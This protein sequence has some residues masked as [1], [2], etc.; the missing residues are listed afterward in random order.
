MTAETAP[1]DAGS[2][3][4]RIGV[5]LRNVGEIGDDW[6]YRLDDALGQPKSVNAKPPAKN[7][8]QVRYRETAF[9]SVTVKPPA[10]NKSLT[11]KPSVIVKPPPGLARE[12]APPSKRPCEPCQRPLQRRG[13]AILAKC[14][15]SREETSSARA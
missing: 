4:T 6:L 2:A 14:H 13:K 5:S 12:G 3:A 10:K 7:K 1:K 9:K 11:A 15:A 8:H